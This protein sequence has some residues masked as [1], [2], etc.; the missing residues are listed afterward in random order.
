MDQ[1]K[2]RC[3]LLFGAAALIVGCSANAQAINVLLGGTPHVHAW[4]FD[5]QAKIAAT[6]RISGNVDVYDESAGLPTLAQLQAYD[7]V[8]FFSEDF[9][10]GNVG[11]GNTLADYVDSGGG[12]VQMTFSFSS[13]SGTPAIGGRWQSGGYSV[14]QPG[15]QNQPGDLTLGTIHDPGNPIMAGVAS[16]NGGTKSYYNTVPSLNPGA[17]AIADW[18]N[19]APLI[20][21]NTTGFSGRVV[22][23]NFYPVSSDANS[24]LGLWDAST[25]GGLLM[26][27]ALNFAAAPEPSTWLLC[28]FGVVGIS[29]WRRF[30][31][32]G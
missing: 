13:T 1:F 31:G 2:T 16:F 6:G 3:K 25:D 7:A 30:A 18:S 4:L 23:L 32:R 28:V 19:G 24:A 17:V 12:I 11:L 21:A 29:A 20:A 8:L 9:I 10:V 22:G 5:V 14:W 26:A 15:Q 27:N